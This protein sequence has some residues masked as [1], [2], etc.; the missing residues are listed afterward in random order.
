VLTGHDDWINSLAFSPDNLWLAT[1][2]RDRTVR[3]WDLNA[4]DPGRDPIR[5]SDHDDEVKTLAF[6]PDSRWLATGSA[7]STSRLWLVRLGDLE[8][9]AC[10]ITGHNFFPDEWQIYF[11]EAAYHKTCEQWP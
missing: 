1:A 3:L 11:L 10:G 9:L 7:D 5:L 2:S 6:S 8:S 4:P